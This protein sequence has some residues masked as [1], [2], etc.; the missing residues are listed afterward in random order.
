[1]LLVSNSTSFNDLS[2]GDVV[3]FKKPADISV[4]IIARIIDIQ[5]DSVGQRIITTKGD[6]NPSPI[7]GTDVRVKKDN[8]IGKVISVIT[9]VQKWLFFGEPY[10]SL[11]LKKG[12][13]LGLE[14]EAFLHGLEIG[15]NC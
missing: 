11:A 9:Q 8:Y 2:I 5:T 1:M 15:I 13:T 10:C 3:V 12:S 4:S 14:F 6:N 7:P